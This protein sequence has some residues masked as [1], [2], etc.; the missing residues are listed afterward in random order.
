MLGLSRDTV[1]HSARTARASPEDLDHDE[2]VYDLSDWAE[3]QRQAAELMLTSGAVPHGWQGDHLV[4]PHVRQVEVDSILEAMEDAEPIEAPP[5]AVPELGPREPLPLAA[6]DPSPVAG[7]ARRLLGFLL[8]LVLLVVVS[9][10]IRQQ[11]AGEGALQSVVVTALIAGLTPAYE[12]VGV[13][14]WGR[15]VGKTIVGTRVVV[16]TDGSVPGWKRAALRWAVPWGPSYLTSWAPGVWGF[17]SLAVLGNAWL[18]VVYWGV[19][20]HPRRQGLHDR[21]AG[22]IVVTDGVE[23][24]GLKS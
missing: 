10:V 4:V 8:D 2:L 14:R 16:A 20:G 13:A 11:L 12:I 5:S 17:L 15:T 7:P 3:E 9:A 6:V 22:T 18:L 1:D 19:L 24:A 23:G 21:V